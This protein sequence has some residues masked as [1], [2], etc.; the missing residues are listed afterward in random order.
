MLDERS[1]TFYI[2]DGYGFI[3]RAFFALPKLTTSKGEHIGAVYGFFKMLITLINSAKPTHMVIALDTGHR[4]FRNDIY[5]KF[6]EEQTIKTIYQE[7]KMEFDLS[8]IKLDDLLQMSSKDLM[9]FLQVDCEKCRKLCE[10]HN[11]DCDK[12]PKVFVI[13]LFLGIEDAIRVEDYKTQYK[14]NRKETPDELKS[15]FKIIREFIDATG[16]KSE[17]VYGFEADDVICSLA[18]NAVKKGKQVVIVSADKD[19]C[20]IVEDGKIEV[21]DPVKKKHLDEQGVIEKF[22]VKSC[23]VCDYLSIIGDAC[24]NV[25]GVNGIGPKGAVKLLEKYGSVENML[26]NLDDIDEKTRQKI[27][28]S[29]DLLKLAHDLIE[30]HDDAIEIADI[31]DYKLH[32]NN[33]TLSEFLTKYEFRDFERQNRAFV[34]QRKGYNYN[35][36]KSNNNDNKNDVNGSTNMFSS[37]QSQ[38]EKR[39]ETKTEIVKIDSKKTLFG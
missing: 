15:Q 33:K 18:K 25:F 6:I 26:K 17:S 30:L 1:D 22:G 9:N 20:Q 4:T 21:Y 14:A 27:I 36:N 23:Q 29:K 7:H 37:N 2:I 3:F 10:C 31:D 12:M 35:K 28:A 24:D 8:G 5:D 34:N 16:I 39:Q 38:Q 13:A 11:V 19:L 32:L